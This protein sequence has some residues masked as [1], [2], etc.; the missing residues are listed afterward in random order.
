M[1]HHN[2]ENEIIRI[3]KSFRNLEFCTRIKG[4]LKRDA[5]DPGKVSDSK[6]HIKASPNDSFSIKKS[7]ALEAADASIMLAFG[8]SA[9]SMDQGLAAAGI[10]IE[11]ESRRPEH[12]LRAILNVIRMSFEAS[13]ASP[14][15]KPH[16]L[17]R[18]I[19][20]AV[21]D[22]AYGDL[23]FVVHLQKL[24][25]LDLDVAH[26]GG[27][28]KWRALKSRVQLL[29]EQAQKDH[30]KG[31]QTDL[32]R[33]GLTD[34]ALARKDRSE[35]GLQ[36]ARDFHAVH[37]HLGVPIAYKT[38]DG[39]TLG[40]WLH[41]RRTGNTSVQ[42][43]QELDALGMDWSPVTGSRARWQ[44]GIAAARDFFRQFGSLDVP[45]GYLTPMGFDLSKWLGTCRKHYARG[46]LSHIE[47]RALEAVCTEWAR[48]DAADNI[49]Q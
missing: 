42:Q 46:I 45:D 39:F 22:D 31:Q 32:G 12:E 23:E 27:L 20:R 8:V 4:L 21:F 10:N 34:V 28:V 19:I 29:L 33:S 3:T 44:S 24:D 16:E 25:G 26:L 7:S 9:I 30:Q 1:N 48:Q 5:I 38:K 37:G 6:S 36:A 47:R 15:W 13:P 11:P 49:R 35:M 14:V 40:R 41:A 18:R 43:R 2:I 17:Q